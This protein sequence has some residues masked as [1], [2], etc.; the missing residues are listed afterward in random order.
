MTT[1]IEGGLP[2]KPVEASVVSDSGPVR[3]GGA[4]DAAVV[5]APPADSLRLTVH[6]PRPNVAGGAC[7]GP[8]ACSGKRW[9]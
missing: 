9:A 5:A 2:A 4:R 8:C 3:A 1:K 7:P 6:E